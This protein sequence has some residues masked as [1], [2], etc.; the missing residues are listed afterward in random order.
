MTCKPTFKIVA[1]TL[2]I[3]L[4]LS[5]EADQSKLE[6]IHLRIERNFPAVEHIDAEGYRQALAEENNSVIVFDVREQSEFDVSHLDG[7]IQVDPDISRQQF[8]QLYGDSVSDKTV[9]FYCSVGQR[10]SLL[11]DR[12]T[13]DL[14]ARGTKDIYNLR[15]GIFGWH[16]SYG[17]L[18]NHYS[19]TD[20]VH[21]YNWRWGRILE[22]RDML[23]YDTE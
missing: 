20:Y 18:V 12:V 16:N 3:L 10:S 14:S 22:R 5:V 15:Y 13:E 1:L 4:A 11:A 7:A 17:E 21:P 19:N 6:K 8:N 2:A 23:R 9:I